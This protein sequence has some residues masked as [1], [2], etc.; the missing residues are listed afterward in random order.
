MCGWKN[1]GNAWDHDWRV[2]RSALCLSVKEPPVDNN[3]KSFSSWLPDLPV[4]A[5]STSDRDVSA[6]FTSPRVPAAFG[7]K[8]IAFAYSVNLG[9]RKPGG[10]ISPARGGLSLLK[11]QEG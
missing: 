4:E 11:R 10:V 6:R 8:C 5:P 2:E 3:K 7:L 9:E 1:D